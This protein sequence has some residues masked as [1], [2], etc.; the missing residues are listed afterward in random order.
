MLVLKVG[1]DLDLRAGLRHREVIIIFYQAGGLF[2][3]V[4][5]GAEFRLGKTRVHSEKKEEF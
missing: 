3:F 5:E 2:H 1:V 4:V